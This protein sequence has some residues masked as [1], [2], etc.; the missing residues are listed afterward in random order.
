MSNSLRDLV[1]WS[2][3]D[4]DT[5]TDPK[6]FDV[7]EWHMKAKLTEPSQ[8]ITTVNIFALASPLRCQKLIIYVK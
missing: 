4:Q 3:S 1:W 8:A 6:P 5:L 2:A 7:P